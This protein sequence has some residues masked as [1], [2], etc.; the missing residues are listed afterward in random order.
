MTMNGMYI[1]QLKIKK[2][3]IESNLCLG[4]NEDDAVGDAL[5]HNGC[6]GIDEVS[7]SLHLYDTVAELG[8]ANLCQ[9]GKGYACVAWLDGGSF[10]LL[11]GWVNIFLQSQPVKR[12]GAHEPYENQDAADDGDDQCDDTWPSAQFRES[13]YIGID[14]AS[15][16]TDAGQTDTWEEKDFQQE[17][18]NTCDEQA[19][20]DEY[21]HF[22]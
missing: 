6:F 16:S 22:F 5:H 13:V 21:V 2:L 20:D 7:R 3:K 4:G 8:I 18:N 19:D 17:Q 9:S 10:G 14:D 12:F 11:H 15:G 1:K